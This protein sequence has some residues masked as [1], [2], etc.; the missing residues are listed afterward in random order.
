MVISMKYIKNFNHFFFKVE[1]NVLKSDPPPYSSVWFK[2]GNQ[3]FCI[4][5]VTKLQTLTL[6]AHHLCVL[7][8][9]S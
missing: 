8:K 7:K 9:L 2:L 5:P 4:H 1:W 6:Y 3:G